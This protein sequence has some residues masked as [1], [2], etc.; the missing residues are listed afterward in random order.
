MK[1]PNAQLVF[2]VAYMKFGKGVPSALFNSL[3]SEHW[4]FEFYKAVSRPPSL[5]SNYAI[6]T[7]CTLGFIGRRVVISSLTEE[8]MPK[9]R[10]K[11]LRRRRLQM[12]HR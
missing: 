8:M 10:W 4:T 1:E 3:M 5:N 11:I 7:D 12:L 6:G 2:T 9:R